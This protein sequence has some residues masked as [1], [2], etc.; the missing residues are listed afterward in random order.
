MNPLAIIAEIDAHSLAT[1]LKPTTICE[2]ALGNARLYERL[3]RR[4]D[5]DLATVA[6]LRSW[7]AQ[8]PPEKT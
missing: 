2:R 8:N 3:K 4:V 6:K 5:N 1:G 7:M